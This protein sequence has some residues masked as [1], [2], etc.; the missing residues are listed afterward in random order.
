[1]VACRAAWTRVGSVLPVRADPT[2]VWE[3]RCL[4]RRFRS[5]RETAV[6]LCISAAT[7]PPTGRGVVTRSS[8][9]TRAPGDG[10]AG[11]PDPAASGP[12]WPGGAIVDSASLDQFMPGEFWCS[13][14]LRE[15]A[16]RSRRLWSTH[17]PS[18]VR[19]K[20]P[21]ASDDRAQQSPGVGPS[22]VRRRLPRCGVARRGVAL[23]GPGSPPPG[24]VS[25]RV[26]ADG[27]ADGASWLRAAPKWRVALSAT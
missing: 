15:L 20:P 5:P 27:L 17:L 6:R 7:D 22:G 12:S 10:S 14:E 1:V 11:A 21:V 13:R 8:S 25:G 24:F 19:R 3:R 18:V 16:V 26:L 9:E 23:C 4:P 2:R